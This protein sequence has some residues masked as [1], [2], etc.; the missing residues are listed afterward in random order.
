M[1]PFDLLLLNLILFHEYLFHLKQLLNR[2]FE[3]FDLVI[4]WL[5]LLFVRMSELVLS[6]GGVLLEL[7]KL[8][9]E[10]LRGGL[11]CGEFLL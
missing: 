1:I 8:L 10:Q 3:L 2:F 4:Q 6:D 11:F 5:D 7:L 9:L